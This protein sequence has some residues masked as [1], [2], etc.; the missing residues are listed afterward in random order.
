M[1]W[2]VQA[3]TFSP[4]TSRVKHYKTASETQPTEAQ[5]KKEERES[6]GISCT[7]CGVTSGGCA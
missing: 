6:S 7:V 2:Q 4:E 1:E 5:D 3:S